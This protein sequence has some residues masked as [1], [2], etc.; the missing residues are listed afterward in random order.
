MS[1]FLLYIE[2]IHLIIIYSLLN[3]AAVYRSLH[4]I[5]T[6]SLLNTAVVLYIY[7]TICHVHAAVALHRNSGDKTDE[8]INHYYVFK[9]AVETRAV[10]TRAVESRTV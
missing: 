10:E 7:V 9:R 1:R 4:S 6:Y 8:P 3:T 2:A 5:I